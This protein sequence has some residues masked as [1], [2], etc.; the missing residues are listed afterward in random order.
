MEKM[1]NGSILEYLDTLF[2]M[3]FIYGTT[4]PSF[5]ESFR[6]LHLIFKY[7][8]TNMTSRLLNNLAYHV[9]APQICSRVES[10]F[11]DRCVTIAVDGQ[12]FYFLNAGFRQISVLVLK[13]SLRNINYFL[14]CLLN[15]IQSYS[16]DCIIQ[17]T[18]RPQI[19][20]PDPSR[21]L[22]CNILCQDFTKFGSGAILHCSFF[23]SLRG[24]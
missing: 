15:L 7:H 5:M 20:Q 17:Y 19:I 12:N 8:S 22:I 14:S 21:R 9:P 6:S 24:L 2:L 11:S 10:L 13:L 18:S 1:L 16:D 23:Q 3:L 4:I